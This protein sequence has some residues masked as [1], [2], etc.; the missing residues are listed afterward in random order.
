MREI[1]CEQRSEEWYMARV[2]RI[3]GSRMKDVRATIKSGEAATRR[4]YRAELI[5]ETLTGVPY[6]DD[7]YQSSEMLWGIQQED[8]AI[9]AYTA[10]TMQ[11]VTKAGLALHPTID[12][13]ASSPDGL[14]GLHG[15]VEVK[16]PKTGTHLETL[17]LG[18]TPSQYRDQMHTGM[19]CC[20]R[21]WCDF[22]SFDPRLPKEYQLIIFRF[23]RDDKEL[24]L[25][26]AAARTFLDEVDQS[27]TQLA[28]CPMFRG[29]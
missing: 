19:L 14:V 5:C 28:K 11:Q 21:D 20:E 29:L 17:M 26:E 22:V 23:M 10:V 9:A 3:T 8:A 4:N 16:C 18:V 2:G 25:I 6:D 12:R 1:K 7:N 15:M 13:V 24:I 27:I